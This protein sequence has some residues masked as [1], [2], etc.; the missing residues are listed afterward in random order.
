MLHLPLYCH[1][2]ES[3]FCIFILVGEMLQQSFQQVQQTTQHT[4]EAKEGEAREWENAG[5][6]I[7]QVWSFLRNNLPKGVGKDTSSASSQLIPN[8]TTFRPFTGILV[9]RRTMSSGK[10]TTGGAGSRGD[11]GASSKSVPDPMPARRKQTRTNRSTSTIETKSGR[12]DQNRPRHPSNRS[13]KGKMEVE[14]N[15][16]DCPSRNFHLVIGKEGKMVEAEKKVWRDMLLSSSLY[17]SF[18]LS[19]PYN[20]LNH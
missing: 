15:D 8:D 18:H 12:E 1:W 9:A 10:T 17:V 4:S 16:R 19:P 13:T 2:D 6:E 5:K 11:T 14:E 20:F 3:H 7:G